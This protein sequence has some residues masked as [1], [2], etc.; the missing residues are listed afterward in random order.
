M[1]PPTGG[2]VMST[3]DERI[4]YLFN[5]CQTAWWYLEFL[6]KQAAQATPREAADT[7]LPCVALPHADMGA[8]IRR[9]KG[10]MDRMKTRITT[11]RKRID[12]HASR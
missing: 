8:T 11:S 2:I 1:S 12:R 6:E 9:S 7:A 5:K 4:E 3:L 10:S